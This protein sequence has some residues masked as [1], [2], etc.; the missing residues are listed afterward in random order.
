VPPDGVASLSTGGDM[1]VTS[2]RPTGSALTCSPWQISIVAGRPP[3]V[4]TS[5]LPDVVQPAR[6]GRDN[7]PQPPIAL[8]GLVGSTVDPTTRRVYWHAG[9][10]PMYH[11]TDVDSRRTRT[12]ALDLAGLGIRDDGEGLC[13][14]E[15]VFDPKRNVAIA[16]AGRP[17]QGTTGADRDKST[18]ELVLALGPNGEARVLHDLNGR[19]DPRFLFLHQFQ[20]IASLDPD[21]DEVIAPLSMVG[22]GEDQLRLNLAT[23]AVALVGASGGARQYRF[24]D[25]LTKKHVAWDCTL[26]GF[27]N[28]V[29]GP[30]TTG[31]IAIPRQRFE[32]RGIPEVCG[33]GFVGGGYD[34]VANNAYVL[35]RTGRIDDPSK[36]FLL[37]AADLA[38]NRF[39]GFIDT[40]ATYG[41]HGFGSVGDLRLFLATEFVPAPRP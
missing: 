23:G 12:F 10:A 30:I 5:K 27:T 28:S 35:L 40:D 24:F 8:W 41:A 29:S 22:V 7:P 37:A 16:I 19:I 2:C 11:V 31:R 13:L 34:P 39:L 4:R 32:A 38:Q 14:G 25:R 1:F 6:F 17:T 33:N 21:R 18:V 3:T 15:W 26:P 20:T 9:C 36:T